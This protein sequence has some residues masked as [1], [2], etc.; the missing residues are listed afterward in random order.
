[1]G[2][3]KAR[4]G[5]TRFS[6]PREIFG[7]FPASLG[8]PLQGA[9]L[10]SSAFIKGRGDP[11]GPTDSRPLTRAQCAHAVKTEDLAGSRLRQVGGTRNVDVPAPCPTCLGRWG[12]TQRPEASEDGC[13]QRGGKEAGLGA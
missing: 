9:S 10:L 5:E 1:M 6:S 3:P 2:T 7:G 11:D 12:Q 8:A 13:S 4:S